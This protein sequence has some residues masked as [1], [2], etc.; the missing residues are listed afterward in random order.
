MYVHSVHMYNLRCFGKAELSLQYPARKIPTGA[1]GLEAPELPNV[2][3]LLGGNGKGK[4]TVLRALVLSTLA[5]VLA[6]QS[7]FLPYRLVRRTKAQEKDRNPVQCLVKS[8]VVLHRTDVHKSPKNLVDLLARLES[9]P[10]KVQ[11]RM[12]FERVP[13]NPL[14]MLRAGKQHDPDVESL[15]GSSANAPQFVDAMYDDFSQAMFMVAYGA[16]RRVET[17]HVDEGSRAKLRAPRYTRVSGIFEDHVAL[18]PLASWLPSA[19]A[20]TAEVKRLLNSI[21]PKEIR[22]TGTFSKLDGQY[23]F[24]KDGILVPFAALSDGY[25]A[26]I[27]WVGDLLG[28]VHDCSPR[29]SKLASMRGVVLVDEIDLHLHPK[30]QQTVVRQVAQAFPALQFVMTTH[31]PLIAGTLAPSNIH[32]MED[33][34]QGTLVTQIREDLRGRTSDQVLE[35]PYFQMESTRDPGTED[36]L[37]VL[38]GRVAKGDEKAA[39]AYI[40]MISR[41]TGVRSIARTRRTTKKAVKK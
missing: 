1:E 25:R 24:D 20:R 8:R 13:A 40:K 30:W 7:G 9:M 4:T 23:L 39:I 31:S 29:T 26:F 34:D 38:A 22:F 5:P 6:E 17:G 28:H 36:Q 15:L 18:R 19:R 21:L 33:A 3:V 10:G 37:A 32:V 2:N 14:K 41:A 11:D 27:G 16:T 35:S 12:V